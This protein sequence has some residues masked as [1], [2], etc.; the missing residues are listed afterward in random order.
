MRGPQVAEG[1]WP[2]GPRS[3]GV[4]GRR[5]GAWTGLLLTALTLG[6]YHFYFHS[7]SHGELVRQLGRRDREAPLVFAYGGLLVY[8]VLFGGSLLFLPVVA[9]AGVFVYMVV[10]QHAVLE[11][12]RLHL[13]L[14]PGSGAAGFLLRLGPGALILVGPFFAYQRLLED[15]NSVWRAFERGGTR[16]HELRPAR[17]AGPSPATTPSPVPAPSANGSTNGSRSQL[18]AAAA[19]NNVDS[20]QGSTRR[21]GRSRSSFSVRDRAAP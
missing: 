10:R 5:R 20:V 11:E 8:G 2:E 21:S 15:Y 3:N 16:E 7:V 6:V 18:V 19:V 14:P 13:G 12:A 9:A 17:R 4:Y 1:Y